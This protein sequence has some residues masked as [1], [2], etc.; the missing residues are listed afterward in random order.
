[1]YAKGMKPELPK[2][3][4]GMPDSLTAV[5][6]LLSGSLVMLVDQLMNW[7]LIARELKC[8][9]CPFGTILA[10]RANEA[11]EKNEARCNECFKKK[12]NQTKYS[13]CAGSIFDKRASRLSIKVKVLLLWTFGASINATDAHELISSETCGAEYVFSE[14]QVR[15]FYK[16]IRLFLKMYKDQFPL[17]K[18]G[19][20]YNTEILQPIFKKGVSVIDVKEQLKYRSTSWRDLKSPTATPC[21]NV[22]T[23]EGM[24]V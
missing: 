12:E 2:V 16:R 17:E 11:Y 8:T 24:L 7:G 1:M 3:K 20:Y 13:F 9:H 15:S 10:W 23:D 22:Q 14:K 21:I 4:E 19:G 5:Y 6:V 18:L